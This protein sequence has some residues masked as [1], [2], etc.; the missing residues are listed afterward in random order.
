[1][2][3]LRCCCAPVTLHG[4][5]LVL[6]VNT[7]SNVGGAHGDPTRQVFEPCVLHGFAVPNTVTILC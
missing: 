4:L 2:P 6:D 1:M 5:F 7:A 3:S